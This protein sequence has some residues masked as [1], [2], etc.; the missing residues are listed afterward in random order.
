MGRRKKYPLNIWESAT[1][2]AEKHYCRI[3]DSL[4]LHPA[5]TALP[6]TAQL[7]YL[8]MVSACAGKMEFNFTA[9]DCEKRGIPRATFM[10]AR[11]KLIKA[12]FIKTI[13]NNQHRRKPN[14]YQF[15]SDWQKIGKTVI[16]PKK[17]D[18]PLKRD[19]QKDESPENTPDSNFLRV[20][21]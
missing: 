5:F 13:E 6:L 8:H 12:G 16:Q 11:D 2:K 14:V 20:S 19:I 4:M 18:A 9:T 10:R 15:C 3:G 1:P 17:K 21:E 7:V